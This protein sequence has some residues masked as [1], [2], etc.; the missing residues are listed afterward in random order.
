MEAFHSFWSEPN[1]RRNQGEIRFPDYEQLTAILSTL[2]WKRH[3]GP[4][5]MMTDTAGAAFFHKIGL[6]PFWDET[7]TALDRLADT[8][9]PEAFWAAGKLRRI[10][11]IRFPVRW[12]APERWNSTKSET[13]HGKTK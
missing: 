13:R 5:R 6:S 9:D 12:N 1:C 10:S 2:E 7:E 8:I 3:S 4:V 11:N